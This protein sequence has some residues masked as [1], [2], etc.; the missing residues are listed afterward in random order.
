MSLAVHYAPS[1][2]PPANGAPLGGSRAALVP[3]APQPRRRPAPAPAELALTATLVPLYLGVRG[4][5]RVVGALESLVR[6]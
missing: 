4:S 6:R 1:P 5:A 2:A 3:V